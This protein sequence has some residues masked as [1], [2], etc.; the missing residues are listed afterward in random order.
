MRIGS[1]PLISPYTLA[2]S[3]K[4][5]GAELATLDGVEPIHCECGN[6]KRG[7]LRAETNCAER[8][9]A[10]PLGRRGDLCRAAGQ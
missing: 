6:E 2:A 7:A 5:A 3:V 4:R 1:T 9:E 8:A 10:R